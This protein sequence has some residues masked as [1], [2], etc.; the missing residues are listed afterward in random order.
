M[1]LR[2]RRKLTVCTLAVSLLCGVIQPLTGSEQAETV[3]PTLGCVNVALLEADGFQ[4]KD[5]NKN[6]TLDPYED[7]RLTPEERAGDLLSRM[8]AEEKAAQMIHITLFRPQETWFSEYNLGFAL[9]YQQ[10]MEGPRAAA[11][12]VNTL[13]E[14]SERSRLGI[15]II[16]S[17]D[18]VHGMS[19]V[20]G[21]TLFPDQVGLAAT[22]NIEL[23][24]RL[25][26]MQR[27]EMLAVGV[28]MSLSP[29]A[30]LST[31]PRW[32]RN[33]E[34]FG[35]DVELASAMVK[36]AVHGLQNGSE[37]SATS[38]LACVKHFPGAGPQLNG[39]DGKPLVFD[40]E[41]LGLH[42]RPFVTAIEAG[43]V[44]I[45]PYGYSK[46]PYL[47]GDALDKT[48]HESYEVMTVLL[49]GE[50][51][52]SGLIQT[53]W[54]MRH[55]DSAL[56]GA[57][58]LGGATPRDIAKIVA[59]VPE[60]RID[61][62]VFQIL[63]V[64]FRLGLFE[65]PY[66]DPEQAEAIVG[67]PDHVALA[68]QAA[69]QSLTL[70]KNDNVLP[71]SSA[72]SILVA[73]P[74]AANADA[75]NSGWKCPGHPGITVLEAVEGRAGDD[76]TVVSTVDAIVAPDLAIVVLGEEANTHEGA[77]GPGKLELPDEQLILIEDLKC[78]GIPVIAVIIM[79]RPLVLTDV[80]DKADAV[81][82]AYRPGMTAGARAIAAALFGD[83]AVTG[84][85]PWQLPRSMEQVLK[86]RED[87]PADIPNPL[88]ERGFGLHLEPFLVEPP[89]DSD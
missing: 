67:S 81:L 56:A 22:G 48:A 11:E 82:I 73:G 24:E 57:D 44:A 70:L 68:R 2:M 13:Q 46:V 69:T 89:G 49:R 32:G 12:W 39:A 29:I 33:Q 87:L 88:F 71:I 75:L 84:S 59:G 64:K 6:G 34:T 66:V 15:P 4:F 9:A 74:L 42:L 51:G 40:A 5:L 7:W 27:T 30:D 86:Q 41:T 20:R 58:I 50:L 17:M 72:T 35:D 60:E 28:R 45:M 53:D 25:A 10:L 21:A 14:W 78:A 8:T 80:V 77:W 52:Y 38:V 85:L 37:L 63:A 54:G 43:A 47:G 55:V 79:G 36:A 19:W 1:R 31:D 18:S 16:I 26:S 23:V 61:R 76:C 65:Q 3:Q 83:S 62:S